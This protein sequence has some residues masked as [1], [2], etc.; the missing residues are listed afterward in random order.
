M[1]YIRVFFLLVLFILSGCGGS[2]SDTNKPPQ[3]NTNYIAPVTLS[4]TVFEMHIDNLPADALSS[5]FPLVESKLIHRYNHHSLFYVQSDLYESWEYRGDYTYSRV[6]ANQAN[7]EATIAASNHNYTIDYQFT[8][9]NTGT[10][11]GS[12][13]DGQLNLQG[14]FSSYP[15]PSFDAH[16]FLGTIDTNKSIQSAITNF[17]YPYHIYLPPNYENTTKNYSVIYVTDGQWQFWQT[18]HAIETSQKDIILIAIEQGEGDRRLIDYALPGS[19]DY[20]NFLQ[21]EMIP[22]IES[23]YRV[24]ANDR[25]IAGFSW[26]GLLVRHALI[27][28]T[29]NSIFSKFIS[30]DGSYWND[31]AIYQEMEQNT[32]STTSLQNRMLYLSSATKQ[33]NNRDVTAFFQTLKGYNLVDFELFFQ[34]LDIEHNQSPVPSIR[35]ALIKLYP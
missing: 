1:A 28:E 19:T 11:Q 17:E 34:P 35:D 7:L 32:Y 21:L 25:A 5:D 10:W 14:S 30:V 33:G 18:A 8:T 16:S 2:D 22:L 31:D 3:I 20:L 15:T 26:G 4:Q 12:F 24:D 29:V 9:N 6:N 23:Q 27:N 13:N